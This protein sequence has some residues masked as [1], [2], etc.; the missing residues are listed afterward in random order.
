MFPGS[1]L[2]PPI[3]IRQIQ[4]E[5]DKGHDSLK[6][7][8]SVGRRLCQTLVRRYCISGPRLDKPSDGVGG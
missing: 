4:D 3:W 1:S 7:R 2:R 5:A 8:E 6:Q